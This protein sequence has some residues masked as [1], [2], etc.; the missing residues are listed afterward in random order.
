M[1]VLSEIIPKTGRNLTVRSF[2]RII[3]KDKIQKQA[4]KSKLN[5]KIEYAVHVMHTPQLG[6]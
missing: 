1:I 2:K 3:N 6:S 4:I 5:Y